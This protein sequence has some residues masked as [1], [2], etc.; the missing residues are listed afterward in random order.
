MQV[1]LPSTTN[2]EVSWGMCGIVSWPS[3][4]TRGG[5][6]YS[7]GGQDAWTSC[8]AG[9]REGNANNLPSTALFIQKS[10]AY[11]SPTSKRM[12]CALTSMRVVGAWTSKHQRTTYCHATVAMTLGLAASSWEYQA[13]DGQRARCFTLSGPNSVSFPARAVERS[14]LSPELRL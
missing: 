8:T 10:Y 2:T 1:Y 9:P 14:K 12:S 5:D 3:Y 4:S 13:P 6:H 11:A 7:K